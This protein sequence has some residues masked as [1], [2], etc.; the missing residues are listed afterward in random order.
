MLIFKIV[1]I[2]FLI[3]LTI[4][5]WLKFRRSKYFPIFLQRIDKMLIEDAKETGIW[6]SQRFG[7]LK[8]LTLAN[9]CLWGSFVFLVIFNEKIPD[10]PE[11]VVALYFG[12]I[13]IASYF[14]YKQRSVEQNYYSENTSG[15]ED[16]KTNKGVAD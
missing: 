1:L 13:G 4:Y 7:Y 2:T 5:T 6:S 11:T 9:L 12:A 10:I 16:E 8:T 3:V 15:Q 14:K